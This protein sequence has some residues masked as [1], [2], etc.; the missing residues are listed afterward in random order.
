M[1]LSIHILD[2]RTLNTCTAQRSLYPN[3]FHRSHSRQD[4][5]LLEALVL[6]AAMHEAMSGTP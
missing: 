6:V 2:N 3:G 4:R 5:C 1:K